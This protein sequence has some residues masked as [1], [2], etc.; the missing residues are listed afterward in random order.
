M[1][2]PLTSALNFTPSVTAPVSEALGV[3]GV[4]DDAQIVHAPQVVDEGV[5]E[6]EAAEAGPVPI[7]LVAVTVKV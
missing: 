2:F 3:V 4:A 1:I 6:F 7:A 5:T